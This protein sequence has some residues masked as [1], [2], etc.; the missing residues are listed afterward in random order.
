[1][2]TV[3]V[4]E[5]PQPPSI[6]N[7]L[8]ATFPVRR[9]SFDFKS[10]KRFWFGND[11]Y[12]T[13]LMNAMSAVFPQGELMLIESLRKIRGAI[14]DPELQAEISAFIGQEAMHAK[15]HMAFN[16]YADEQQIHIENLQDEVK[17]L[18]AYMQKIL[19]P[20]H[21]MAIGCAIEHI[22]ATLGA[23]LLRCDEW[24]QRLSGPVGELWLW[25][26][27]EENEHKAVFFD[28]YV[29][30]GGGYLSRIF[31]MALAG[32]IVTFL[33]ANNAR[34][35]LQAEKLLSMK[36]IAQFLYQATGE[37]GL[38]TWKVVKDF[39]DYYRPRFHPFQH[40]T[41]ALEQLWHTRLQLT[42]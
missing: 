6:A 7:R 17:N 2:I 42:A 22:T 16:R 28:A 4:Q 3:A 31:Y 11:A 26:A 19:P 5:K 21:I 25:H 12:F 40:D 32:S 37:G 30:A 13:H 24:N 36:G 41:K 15:E 35:L 10:S 8:K 29:A 34:R 27:V 33:I 14:D 18:Y 39:M 38:I 23:Q 1:M 20:M 9:L